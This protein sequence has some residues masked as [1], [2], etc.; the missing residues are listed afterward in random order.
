[1]QL[2][3]LLWH[4]RLLSNLPLVVSGIGLARFVPILIF[5][6]FGGWWRMPTTGAKFC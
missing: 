5:A 1:M 6:P 4:L 2:A 3:A